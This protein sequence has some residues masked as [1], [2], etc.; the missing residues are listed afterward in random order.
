MPKKKNPPKLPTNPA[1][2]SQNNDKR[3]DV[4]LGAGSRGGQSPK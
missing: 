4:P 1:N 3:R 2:L